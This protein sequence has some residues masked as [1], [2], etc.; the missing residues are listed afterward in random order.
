MANEG[1]VDFPRGKKPEQLIKRIIS[2]SSNE[3]DLVLDSFLGSGTTAAVAQK[4][5]RRY[6]GIEMGDHAYTHCKVRLDKVIDGTDQ[7]GISKAVNWQGGGAYKFYDLAPTLINKDAFGEYVINKAYDAAMIASA[8]ALHEGFTYKPDTTLFWKQSQGNENSYLFVTTRYVDAA[9]LS[10]IASTMQDDEYLIIACKSFE[11]GLEKL[12]PNITIKKI[13]QML[14]N[15]C[16]FDHDNY[17]LNIVNPPVYDDEED[18][19][20]EDGCDEQ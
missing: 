8:V 10:A 2:I 7:G 9:Y 4:M 13:P 3:G 16:E 19:K 1:T 6:I 11:S 20:E 15:R 18:E 14:F 12:Y 5:N 17:N